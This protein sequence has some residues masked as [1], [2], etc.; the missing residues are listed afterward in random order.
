MN[1]F[2]R[3]RILASTHCH[4]PGMRPDDPPAKQAYDWGRHHRRIGEPPLPGDH[5]D[6]GADY[7][8]GYDGRRRQRRHR[9]TLRH[10]I[11]LKRRGQQ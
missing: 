8:R 11:R 7:N 2:T 3:R 9:R 4:P 10:R 1:P 6:Y 5:S